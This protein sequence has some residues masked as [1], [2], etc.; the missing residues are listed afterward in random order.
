MNE[1]SVGKHYDSEILFPN[2]K[3]SF[4]F[5]Y[6]EVIEYNHS[7]ESYLYGGGGRVETLSNG[8]VVGHTNPIQS[9][10]I[11]KTSV[12]VKNKDGEE[13]ITIPAKISLR[14][15]HKIIVIY[16]NDGIRSFALRAR[17]INTGKIFKLIDDNMYEC[18]KK[19]FIWWYRSEANVA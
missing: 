15:G 14:N 6:G 2:K 10:N 4:W 12:W 7:S 5:K 11:H 8:S 16:A 1:I 18:L 17:N 13:E 9:K 19:A 3:F